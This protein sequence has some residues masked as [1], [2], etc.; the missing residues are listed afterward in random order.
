VAEKIVGA[1]YASAL[2]EENPGAIVRG[3]PIPYCPRPVLD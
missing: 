1:E 3:E 2:V